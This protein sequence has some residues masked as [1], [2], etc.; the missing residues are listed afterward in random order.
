MKKTSKLINVV[1]FVNKKHLLE[2]SVTVSFATA[3]NSKKH[4]APKVN[5]SKK[6]YFA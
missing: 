3:I 2:S 4:L 5:C 6:G 1:Q